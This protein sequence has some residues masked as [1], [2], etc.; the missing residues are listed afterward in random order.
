MTGT[1]IKF[2]VP[3][4]E[5]LSKKIKKSGLTIA[6]AGSSSSG[7]STGAKAIAKSLGLEYV[8]A[9]EIQRMIA[10]DKGISLEEQVRMR[11]KEVDHEMDRRNLQ[12]AIR[13]GV[14]IDARLSGWCAGDW[15]D[16]KI[17]YDCPLEVRAERAA[18]RDGV[19][20]EKSLV[21]IRMRDEED[22]KKY[23]EL[24]GIDAFDKSI[25]DFIIDNKKL[26]KDQ[27]ET[28]PVRMVNEF[29]EKKMKK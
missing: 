13:G 23:K 27:A 17:F 8:Y 14:V 25:Y 4:Q 24:Y 28:E 26:T 12:F 1:F 10:K 5:E 2:L 29:L 6:V 19:P 9:G 22:N 16:V 11:G 3:F 20:L 18:I 7:K 21:N 15:A